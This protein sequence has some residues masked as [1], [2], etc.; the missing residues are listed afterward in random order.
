MKT[1]DPNIELRQEEIR[2]ILGI[3]PPWVIRW[4]SLTLALV[5]VGLILGTIWFKY[6]DR[7][8]SQLTLT[9]LNPP[10]MMNARQNGRIELLNVGD[11]DSVKKGQLLAVLESSARYAD[12]FEVDS[13]MVHYRIELA[14]P[15][16]IGTLA[17]PARDYQFGEW[18]A[19]LAAFSKARKDLNDF[20]R[21]GSNQAR[22]QS[23]K[24]QLKHYKNYYEQQNRQRQLKS[25][26]MDIQEKQYQRLV[27]LRDSNT[28]SLKDFEAGESINLKGKYDL[29][30]A[31]SVLSLTQIEI[32]QLEHQ[33]IGLEKDFL[34]AKDQKSNLLTQSFDQLAG[35]VSNWKLNY[36]FIAPVDGTVTFTRVWNQNQYV[37]QGDRVM[38]IISGETGPVVG[39]VLL[40]LRG[41]GKV[42]TGQKVIVRM[43]K[44]P[45]MEYGSLQGRVEGIS[46]VS[47]QEFYSVE[48]SFPKGLKTT[49]NNELIFNQGMTGQAEIIT[50]E[51]SLILRIVNPLRSILKRNAI[52]K[53]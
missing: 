47:D 5:F 23:I 13:L 9:T 41:S 36:A 48:I 43:D 11:T 32:D 28:I 3:V 35:T 22:I 16:S 44:Y 1:R 51:I 14:D 12:I 33:I 2:E 7:I 24:K 15:D 8:I 34:E 18:Q 45:Y 10:V 52:L 40:P 49:Y 29:E 42:K 27:V 37:K 31:R 4:G 30:S 6:P 21:L 25:E 38:T 26:E 53:N 17:F 39:R 19:S 20:N 50:D 46:L